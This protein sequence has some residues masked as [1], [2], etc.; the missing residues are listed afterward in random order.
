MR[1][2][3]RA[4]VIACATKAEYLAY[5]MDAAEQHDADR[6]HPGQVLSKA[7]LRVAALLGMRHK[8]L[9]EVIGTSPSTISRLTKSQPLR[10]GTKPAELAT[11]L[12]RMYRSL[13]ALV[14]GDTQ[15]ARAWFRAHNAHLEGRPCDR[16]GTVEGLVDVVRY[17]DAMRGR[18]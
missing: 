10:V 14:G 4:G 13:D 5:E 9:A 16:I 7:A 11:L 8:E 1:R 6:D 3:D 18:V 2:Q 17:L 12:V 15:K